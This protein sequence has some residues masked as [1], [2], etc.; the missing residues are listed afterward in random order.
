[1]SME[2]SYNSTNQLQ[3]LSGTA[4]DEDNTI[5]WERTY[6]RIKLDFVPCYSTVT[7]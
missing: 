5:K 2:K 6:Q 1:M 7:T 3:L 4:L